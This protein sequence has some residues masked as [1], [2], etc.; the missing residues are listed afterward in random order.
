MAANRW[1][2]V[3]SATCGTLGVLLILVALLLGY[4]TRSLFNEGAFASRVASS[5]EDPRVANFVAE[6][7]A[8]AEERGDDPTHRVRG[9]RS[10]GATASPARRR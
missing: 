1:R 9:Q 3:T 5:L 2:R 8:D 10:S 4:A 7:L 6:Q